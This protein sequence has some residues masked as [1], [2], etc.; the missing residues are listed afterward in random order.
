MT[1]KYQSFQTHTY[2]PIYQLVPVYLP[3]CTGFFCQSRILPW[4]AI[5]QLVPV[6]PHL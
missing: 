6:W 2:K 3:T 5:Y 1:E 4:G